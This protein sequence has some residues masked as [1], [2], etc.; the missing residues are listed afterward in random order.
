MKNN[1][2]SYTTVQKIESKL[3][4]WF[5][6]SLHII[7]NNDDLFYGIVCIPPYRS[8]FAHDDPYL[9]L[10]TEIVKYISKSNNILL[11]GDFNSRTGKNADYIECDQ[12]ESTAYLKFAKLQYV[13]SGF[14][15]RVIAGSLM[16]LY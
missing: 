5:S 15:C 7:P 9:E 14:R 11:F 10:Q 6:V 3:I 16:R 4:S 1:L 13:S 8:K 2:S 12:F